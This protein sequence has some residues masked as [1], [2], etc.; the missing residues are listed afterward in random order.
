MPTVETDCAFGLGKFDLAP[1]E[2]RSRVERSLAAVGMLEYLQAC[3]V[4]LQGHVLFR[5]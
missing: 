1:D 3:Y 4:M 5:L 2:V